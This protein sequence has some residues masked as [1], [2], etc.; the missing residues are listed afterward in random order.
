MQATVAV[1]IACL[2]GRAVAIECSALFPAMYCC[3]RPPVDPRTQS[4]AG[5]TSSRY[6]TSRCYARDGVEC[7]TAGIAQTY[8]SADADGDHVEA[9]EG[10]FYNVSDTIFNTST[11]CAYINPDKLYKFW[12]ATTL[13]V[14][15]GPLGLDRFYLG[16][17]A[18]GLAK[19]STAGFLCLGW[20][21]DIILISLQIV[22]PADGTDYF[23]GFYESRFTGLS[24]PGSEQSGVFEDYTCAS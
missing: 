3:V 19:L 21:I 23:M 24:T 13:S 18:I 7:I 11:P 5:C 14:F 22:T 16:Y 17:Y 10:A 9:C 12:V 8:T 4:Y 6:V 15:L 1:L 2:F 20:V